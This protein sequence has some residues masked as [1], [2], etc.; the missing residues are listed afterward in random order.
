[1]MTGWRCGWALAPRQVTAAAN[2]LMSHATSHANSITQKAVIAAL[3]GS[4][5]SVAAMLAEYRRRRD[6]LHDWLTAESRIKCGRPAGAFYLFVDVRDALS[7]GLP[8]SFD[9]ARALL[10]E[11]HV[12]L[13][14]GEAF[15]AP[16]FVRIS[17]ATSM[18]TLREGSRRLIDFV[19]THSPRTVAA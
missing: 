8:T 11:A 6:S 16:G 17:Y 2:A 10:D 15:E 19:R 4:Q 13:T 9:F 12:A 7:G 5:A 18:D 14:P 1:A 3:T